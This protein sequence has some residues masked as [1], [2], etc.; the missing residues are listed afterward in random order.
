MTKASSDGVL[1]HV[2]RLAAAQS[3]CRS[4]DAELLHAFITCRDEDA[5]TALVRRHGPLVRHV[6]RRVLH[7]TQ[8][9]EDAFQATFLVLA[10]KAASVH[11]RAAL[12]SWLYGAARRMALSVKRTAVRRRAYEGQVT[13]VRPNDPCADLAWREVQALLDE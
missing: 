8:D 13:P 1:Q 4:T 10:R 12:A 9:A 3:N 2:W 6:C 7:N 11:R 5:F